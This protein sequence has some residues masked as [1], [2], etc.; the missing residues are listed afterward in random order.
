MTLLIMF[1]TATLWAS[2][3]TVTYDFS[4]TGS[5]TSANGYIRRA[6]N[7]NYY[8]TWHVG[9]QT[10]W[11]A[12][13]SHGVNDEY[14]ITFKPSVKLNAYTY[15]NTQTKVFRTTKSTSFVVSTDASNQY[16]IKSVVFK[17]GSDVQVGSSNNVNA[18]TATVN[19]STGIDIVHVTVTLTPY[20]DCFVQEGNVYTIKN[21]VGWG[22]FCDAVDN[23]D[24]SNNFSGK[25]VKL[26][27]DISVNRMVGTS[28]HKFNGTFDGQGHTLTFNQGT[29]SSQCTTQNVAP[30]RY[31]NNA[32]IQNLRTTGTIYTS[33][34]NAGG[35]IA[36][37]TGDVTLTNCRSSM[38]INSSVDGDGT[39]GGLIAY[40]NSGSGNM[41]NIDGCLFD[42][43]L[44]GANT[45]SCGGFIG[46]RSGTATI[47]NSMFD[48]VE[49]TVSN[50]YGATF[51][52][53][54]VDTYNSYYTYLLNDGANYPPTL[55]D[56]NVSPKKY[57]N[58]QQAYRV[59]TSEHIL[60]VPNENP[61][62]YNV[63]GITA[64]AGDMIKYGNTYYAGL[65]QTVTVEMEAG[66][67]T[68]ATP[69]VTGYG[70]LSVPV[71]GSGPWT[72]SMPAAN[73]FVSATTGF[74]PAH[75]SYDGIDTYT[76][77]SA[78]G[79]D[80]FCD[81]L[82]DNDTWDRFT[83]KTVQLGAENI[84][85]TRMAGSS[86]H[87]MKGT[88]DGQG[89]TI[90]VNYG[91]AQNPINEDNV[92]PFRNADDG[93][94]IKN[95]HV[96]GHIYTSG[97]YAAG[98]VGTQY[99]AVTIE[100][101]R[102][103]V[104]IHSRTSGDGTHGGLLGRHAGGTLDIEG[105]VF[106][107]KM[108]TEGTTAT[109]SCGGLVGW[110]STTTTISN[111]IY[112]P[113]AIANNE[114]EV[115]TDNSATIARQNS[116]ASVTIT[117]CYYTRTLNTVQGQLMHSI[118]PGINTIITFDGSATEHNV[119]TI[120]AYTFEGNT[121]NPGL[122]YNSTCYSASGN[123]VRLILDAAEGHYFSGYTTSPATSM[124]TLSS[125]LSTFNCQ[126][127]MPNGNV[128]ITGTPAEEFSIVYDL[129]GGT[130]ATANPTTYTNQTPTFTLVN[131]TKEDYTFDGW[132]GTG[133][134]EL[135]MTVTIAQ[136]ST[137]HRSYT[138][139]WRTNYP[140][141]T[142]LAV[143]NVAQNTATLSWTAGGSESS[144]DIFFTTNANEVPD[145]TTTP[146]TTLNAQLSPLTLTGLTAST[147]YYVYVRAVYS[148]NKTSL[149]S[150]PVVF[151]TLCNAEALPY[152][153]DF[154]NSPVLSH[155]WTTHVY[156]H[157][158]SSIDI[159]DNALSFRIGNN[160]IMVAVLP[161]MDESEN[162]REYQISFDAGCAN[163]DN[164]Y[165]T[166]G[167]I[168]IGI[169]DD[170]ADMAT[171]V[172]IKAV[173]IADEYPAYG[174][175]MVRFNHYTGSGHYIAIKNK[176][177][178][179]GYILIDNISVTELPTCLEPTD[180]T[181]ET[182]GWDA[183]VNWES[184][185]SGASYDVALSTTATDHPENCSTLVHTANTAYT[186]SA[187]QT[188]YG[189]NYVYVRTR[190]GE[191]NYSEWVGTHFVIGYCTPNIP[192]RDENGIIGVRFGS[193]NHIVNLYDPDGLPSEKPYYGDYTALVGDIQANADDTIYIT[194]NTGEY[195]SYVYT[196]WVDL[197]QD[198]L[199]EDDELLWIDEAVDGDATLKAP[200]VIPAN[201]PEGDY[202]MRI[203]S[204][205]E[206][207][208][209]FF[210]NGFI[211]WDA[212]HDVCHGTSWANA[213]DFTIHVIP[214][215]AC[216][217]P[218]DLGF[219]INVDETQIGNKKFKAVLHWKSNSATPET[220]WTLYWKQSS[221]AEYTEVSIEEHPTCTLTALDT[222]TD[223]E[224]YVVAHLEVNSALQTS[225]PSKVC[226]FTTPHYPVNA[227]WSENF[228]SLTEPY[229]IPTR[230]D[231]SEGTI[232]EASYKWC[233][234]DET[235]DY[236]SCNGTS[237][238]GSKC[239]RFNSVDPYHRETNYLKT[240]PV[241]L[242]AGT[243]M[244]LTF[245]YK[246]P[247]GGD[248][249][250]LL[251]TDGG[252][253]CDTVFVSGLKVTNWTQSYPIYLHKYRGQM[254]VFV[255]KGTSNWGADDSFLYLD[256]VEVSAADEC[257]P[258][259]AVTASA[260]SNS[261]VLNWIG[262]TED[263]W[264]VYYRVKN[265]VWET[266]SV[267]SKPPYTLTNLLENTDYEFYVKANCSSN[268][269]S[270]SSDTISFHTLCGA[271]LVTAD[272]PYTENFET[273]EGVTYHNNVGHVPD[274]W[275]IDPSGDA[276]YA[277]AKVLTKE[278]TCNFT[279][280]TDNNSQ[281]LY[282]YGKGMN[283]AALPVFENSIRSLE[284]SF[285]YAFESLQG[286][287]SL[288]LGFIFPVDVGFN[289]FD[290][291]S[292]ITINSQSDFEAKKFY[293]VTKNLKYEVPDRATRLVFR[294]YNKYQWGCNVDDIVIKL[295]SDNI[296]KTVVGY[297]DDPT[298]GR[299]YLIAYPWYG[300]QEIT[301]I[302]HLIPKVDNQP[303]INSETYD[304]YRFDQAAGQEWQNYKA[305][306]GV[307]NAVDSTFTSLVNGQGYLYASNHNV[308][309]NF[310]GQPYI[311]DGK[312]TLTKVEGA[313]LEGWNLVGN[314]F[315][316]DATVDKPFY[317]MNDAGTE[318]IVDNSHDHIVHLTEGIFVHADN[319]GDK[320]TFTPVSQG[321]KGRSE[322]RASLVLNLFSENTDNVIDRAIVRLD[323][324]E[325]LP[326]LQIRDNSTKIYIPQEGKDYAIV[327]ADRIN[328]LP[329]CFKTQHN[330]EYTVTV[331][332]DHV[333]MSY[334][335]L[336]DNLTGA[337]IDLLEEPSYTFTARN[338]DY[339]S[340][341]KLVFT[342]IDNEDDNENRNEDFAF[343]SNGEIFVNGDGIVQVVDM[344]G[345]VLVNRE[346]HSDFRLPTSDFSSGVYVLRLI[347]GESART[348]KIVIK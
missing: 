90:T 203:Y 45:H 239:V 152:E 222:I 157:Y 146:T 77:H 32:T 305:H 162:L 249:S 128:T 61:T 347:N 330:G 103:S 81:F 14:D 179:N 9:I 125:Q 55:A 204:A 136:S 211:D 286:D 107:G 34:M 18:K 270:Q 272:H 191:N 28:D 97:K 172:E 214:A 304:L 19:V 230:W 23:G 16:L 68:T 131:P 170:P 207:F 89:H 221:D 100:N 213:C 303:V 196:I 139:H 244:K 105:C 122:K 233:Y 87:D 251:S 20:S 151:N 277:T 343:I 160:N 102:S 91:T 288:T 321:A 253:T 31:V 190:C 241:N 79:W 62:V 344:M 314:P 27:T 154:N 291:I 99:G 25:T 256:D 195:Y 259:V 199:F 235:Y 242:P 331:D 42:G 8:T 262:N 302:G 168:V 51:A 282:F 130:V 229:S 38:V 44:R 64:Y 261:A 197:N 184:D 57:N 21:A 296:D 12:N 319:D 279:R 177:L 313:K 59:T 129:D 69:T 110:C 84:T 318:I 216:R 161:E 104:T 70:E 142:D 289:T 215:P 308:T 67:A 285:K 49:V 327:S 48:P 271:I 158:N 228:N 35:I 120:T 10:L 29:S 127:T 209:E 260:V 284:I 290:T 274:C 192:S 188:H 218:I 95:L 348:Q 71:S 224:F 132:T 5:E 94:I 78:F 257:T 306:N 210:N 323:E 163:F 193:G 298:A 226:H 264:T 26:D 236:G 60:V 338:D 254:V 181:V 237:H 65:D 121:L 292:Y 315:T 225:A 297:G 337:N 243:P 294:W 217:P 159:R 180:L 137:G 341:F 3:I 46:W 301:D 106:D 309:L 52:R 328:Q 283:Y 246:N 13:T 144:W 74:D 123:E 205:D 143:S 240:V 126:L 54:G 145:Y 22:L 299:W 150:G 149:W 189:D 43:R 212:P 266:K 178:K 153:E 227:P 11:P 317:R 165:M 118:L 36:N 295:R 58:G 92:A 273:T 276:V 116:S 187:P 2:D 329:L 156:D 182:V 80:M 238:D 247:S 186:F 114:T 41:L 24:N 141:P 194:T 258:P 37:S 1:T 335:H 223:Y 76:I 310:W 232:V 175:H 30:F 112:A 263:E 326:K 113:A 93:C 220:D 293:Q 50:S 324:G 269:A 73:V 75:F 15:D 316:E 135:T 53:N 307:G 148:N 185:V 219:T 340:R 336:I 4:W 7:S 320:V 47:H 345:H 333:G 267:T 234:D 72:F 88:F 63:S 138:A 117:N 278:S 167:K 164:T 287:G 147:T 56:G 332:L 322:N 133:L 83:G 101:C 82:Q 231:N 173:D 109:H 17:N 124:T 174:R 275:D 169:M 245:W 281:V 183:T 312:I 33:Q 201:T 111:S 342:A 155:C 268:S 208:N 6:D 166:K 96:A 66:Y 134:T 311:G 85:V 250:V 115:G 334:L 176:Y 346:I 98:F 300:S 252:N 280:G 200:I 40:H 198:L 206:D 108:L 248:Y 265:G 171:F 140:A 202:R 325:T 339:A 255:F 119:S 86:Y 39:H